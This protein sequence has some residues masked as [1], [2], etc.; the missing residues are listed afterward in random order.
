MLKTL[1]IIDTL[2]HYGPCSA[3][4]LMTMH[5]VSVATLKRHIAEARLLGADVAS[6][7]VGASWSFEL[8]NGPKVMPLCKRWIELERGRTLLS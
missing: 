3:A 7:K 6:V 5:T 8:L 4:T 1:E 2:N